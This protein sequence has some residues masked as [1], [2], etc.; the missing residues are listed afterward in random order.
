M[1]NQIMIVSELKYKREDIFESDLNFEKDYI[2]KRCYSDSQ[3][4][5][6]NPKNELPSYNNNKS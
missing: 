1:Q 5:Y 6:F 2:K 4:Q 3:I